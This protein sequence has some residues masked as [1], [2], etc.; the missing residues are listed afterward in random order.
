MGRFTGILGLL[1]MLG[2]AYAFSTNRRTVRVKTVDWGLGPQFV[3]AV[4][5]FKIGAARAVYH[6]SLY[7]LA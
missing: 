1:T 3:F 2:L 6:I 7:H 5:V 4:F